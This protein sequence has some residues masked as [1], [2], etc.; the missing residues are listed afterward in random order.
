MT[1][2][3][4]SIAEL[5]AYPLVYLATPYTKYPAGIGV[6]FKHAAIV[7]ARLM[8]AGV[9]VYSPIAHTHPLA[10]HGG[11]DP[12]DH[13]IWLPYDRAMMD[14]AAALAVALMDGW[15]ESYGVQHEI[16]VFTTLAKPVHYVEVVHWLG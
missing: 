1:P 5:A 3:I 8:Q 7:A 10:V 12:L 15:R 6:A 2:A 13:T 9:K 14:A 4:A 16:A 11:L